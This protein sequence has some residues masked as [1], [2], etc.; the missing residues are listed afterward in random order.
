L[1]R[2]HRLLIPLICFLLPAGL[3]MAQSTDITR[4]DQIGLV[5]PT[6]CGQTGLFNVVTADTLHR[7]DWS[8]GVYLNDYDLSAG[9][10]RAFVPLSARDYKDMG[11]DQYR[12]ST[13]IGY[14]IN[15]R[16]EVSA[17]LP[18]D[19]LQ[20]HGGDR[21]G[22][23]NG[24]L[25]QGRF[26]DSGLGDLR[27][28]TKFMLLPGSGPG[29]SRLALSLFTDVPTGDSNSGISTGNGNFG[30][31]AH[32][33]QG[34]FTLGGQYTIVGKRDESDRNDRFVGAGAVDLPNQINVDAGINM[35]LSFWRTTNWISEASATFYN[36]GDVKPKAPLY[37]VTGLRHWFGDSGWALN[38]GVRWNVAHFS[39][40]NDECRVTELDD[41]ALGGLVG[42]TYAPFHIARAVPPPPAP[43]PVPPPPPPP[44]P[45]APAPV[46]PPPPPVAPPHQPTELRTDEIHFEP[47]SARLTNIAKAILDDVALRMKQEPTATAIVIGYN[48]DR[49][50]KGP[51]SDLD[52][53]RAEAVRD[54][55]VTRHGIDPARI[56]VEA[57]D[58]NNPV[59]DNT[60]AEGRLKNRRVVIRLLIP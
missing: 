10:A 56:S 40:D 23:I 58:G 11:Y 37:L 16:W 38:A 42:I 14:G 60:T 27:L 55:L 8:F 44:P 25:Y 19:R 36:G 30:L 26:T 54:Y 3:A 18:W 34:M 51:N 28:A 32:W 22:F 43:T 7:G 6:A 20:G 41:C 29:T 4:E 45:P 39:N 52:R 53:R 49:E 21:A 50:A 15:D 9:P 1:F 35:P 47:G 12:L 2:K 13:S 5:A 33:T 59:G 17:M 57:G 24:Y 46:T 48:D 31:G